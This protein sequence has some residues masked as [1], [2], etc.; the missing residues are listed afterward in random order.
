MACIIND[1][2]AIFIWYLGEGLSAFFPAGATILGEIAFVCLF[3]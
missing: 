2:Q 3:V 1:D